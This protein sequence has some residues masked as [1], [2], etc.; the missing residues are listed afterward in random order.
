MRAR[1]TTVLIGLV[2]ILALGAAAC[3][4]D[5]DS[6]ST[7]TT[8][9][10]QG[11]AVQTPEGQAS[12][13]LSGDLPPNWPSDFPVPSGAEPAGSGSLGGTTSTGLVGVYSTSASAEDTYNFYRD[14]SELQIDSSTSI[15]GGSTYVGTV[16]FSGQWNGSVTVLPSGDQTLI[17]ILLS[18]AGAGTTVGS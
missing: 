1:R 18:Q 3:S 12:L 16:Q 13:S 9:S 5:D 2:A 6:S 17:V 7:T 4:D 8:A 14:N 15:G 11:F 10:N